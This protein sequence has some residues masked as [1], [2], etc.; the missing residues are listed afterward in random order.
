MEALQGKQRDEMQHYID[1]LRKSKQ[2][3]SLE[4]DT[5]ACRAVLL[6]SK[7]GNE[8]NPGSI[9]HFKTTSM[10]NPGSPSDCFRATARGR[11]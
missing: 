2:V 5:P 1:L 6:H 9:G 7:N 8:G 4:A 10:R 11:S 3:E